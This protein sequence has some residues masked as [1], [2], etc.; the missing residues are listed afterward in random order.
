MTSLEELEADDDVNS[1]DSGV[2]LR[3]STPWTQLS[4]LGSGAAV[5]HALVELLCSRR[6]R[7]P[8]NKTVQQS[9]LYDSQGSQYRSVVTNS[10]W[11]Q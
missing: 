7:R 6:W 4:C 8:S 9:N 11:K 5:G 2:S 3:S 10:A 1:V